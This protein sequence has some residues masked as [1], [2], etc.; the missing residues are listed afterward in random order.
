MSE[1]LSI[2]MMLS[3]MTGEHK[4]AWPWI[5]GAIG[6][7]ALAAFVVLTVL[8][9]KKN[10]TPTDPTTQP[11]SEDASAEAE[12]APQDAPTADTP[13]ID[14]SSADNQDKT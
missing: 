2:L 7:L 1:V 10:D 11:S 12:A 14:E 3:P 5:V 6:V 8:E 13:S 4:S 9:K